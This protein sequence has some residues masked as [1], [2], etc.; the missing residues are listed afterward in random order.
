MS[1][2]HP[3][4]EAMNQKY[5]IGKLLFRNELRAVSQLLQPDETLR[6]LYSCTITATHL[7]T[8][9]VKKGL[10]LFFV[11]NHRAMHV[12]TIL[13]FQELFQLDEIHSVVSDSKGSLKFQATDRAVQLT[14]LSTTQAELATILYELSANGKPQQQSQAQ[15]VVSQPQQQP[16][17]P[18]PHAQPAISSQQPLTAVVCPRCSASIMVPQGSA[19]VCEYCSGAVQG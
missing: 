7:P 16:V 17:A 2:L 13:N 15:P 5:S 14:G 19:A 3:Q 4:V 8:G 9:A 12:A 10:G 18:Q 6:Y 1:K 11:S